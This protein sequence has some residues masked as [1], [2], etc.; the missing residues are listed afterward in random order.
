[1]TNSTPRITTFS[2]KLQVAYF[3]NIFTASFGI[4]RF[5]ILF[6]ELTFSSYLEPV[7][8]NDIFI[9]QLSYILLLSSS[10]TRGCLVYFCCL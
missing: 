8:S 3:I 6:A 1:V 4:R 9:P 7:E 10:Y 5:I 2:H